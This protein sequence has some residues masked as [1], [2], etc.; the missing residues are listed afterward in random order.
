MVIGA[1][2]TEVSDLVSVFWEPGSAGLFESGLEDMSVSAFD[3]ARADRQ[4]QGQGSWVVQRIESI[5][6]IAMALADRGF[7]VRRGF[8]F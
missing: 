4:A 5:G 8:R 6:Q 3:D 7:F 2:N 1:E